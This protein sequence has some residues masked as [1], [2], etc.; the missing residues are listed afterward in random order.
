[1]SAVVAV[2]R[3]SAGLSRYHDNRFNTQA[4]ILLPADWVVSAEDDVAIVT[5]LGSCV[6]AC[7]R[8]PVAGIGGMNHFMLPDNSSGDVSARYGTHAMELLINSMLKAGAHRDNIEAKVFGGGNVLK[9]F[10]TNP[11]G[12]RNAQFVLHYL[13]VEG[14]AVHGKDLYGIHPRKVWFFP[15]SGRV[16]V[17]RLPHAHDTA[18]V[19]EEI[20]YRER[21]AE[22]PRSG[23]I[24]LFG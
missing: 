18:V 8:D 12:T 16:V 7:L 6:S 20:A 9:G 11:V 15:V 19:R 1:M 14:I 17:Q 3:P 10:T 23:D 4:I 2:A 22:Q 13:R 21:L 24:E 5:V